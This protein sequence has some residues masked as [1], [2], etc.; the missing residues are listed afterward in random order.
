MG[1]SMVLAASR[2]TFA[3]SRDGALPF[4]SIL[5][6]INK[7]TKT[8]VN[9]VSYF[10]LPIRRVLSSFTDTSLGLVRLLLG[11]RPRAPG[12][13]WPVGHQRCL[14]SWG[15]GSLYRL[16]SPHLGSFPWN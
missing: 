10:R 3:F 2:Q 14:F 9:T 4:S 15:H 8:P 6:R 16:Q 11:N 12:L 13:C 5:Y 7:T 1:S